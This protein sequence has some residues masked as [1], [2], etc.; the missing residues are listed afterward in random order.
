[1]NRTGKRRMIIASVAV[2]VV[3][4]FAG[5]PALAGWSLNVGS[6]C[7]DG[8]EWVTRTIY[9][10][11]LRPVPK[12]CYRTEQQAVT[13]WITERRLVEEVWYDNWGCRRTRLVWKDIQVPRT[14]YR[15]VQVPY[16][17]VVYEYVQVPYVEHIRVVRPCFSVQTRN[18]SVQVGGS[19]FAF[20]LRGDLGRCPPPPPPTFVCGRSRRR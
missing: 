13:V 10:T 9:R 16:E 3:L 14:E 7:D 18:F 20:S 17:T 1:M 8:Y 5:A 4:A 11:E 15:W 19:G 12:V 6:T 2:V